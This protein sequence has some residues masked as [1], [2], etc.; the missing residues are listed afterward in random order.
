[1]TERTVSPR[2][3]SQRFRRFKFYAHKT[4]RS[5]H[6]P[7]VSTTVRKTKQVSLQLRMQAELPLNL[8]VA[9]VAKDGTIL[10]KGDRS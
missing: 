6:H 3:S 4:I 7:E 9:G 5:I 2:R 10:T 8:D 1:M